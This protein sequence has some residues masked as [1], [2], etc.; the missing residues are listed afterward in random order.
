MDNRK[1]LADAKM[2]SQHFVTEAEKISMDQ[3]LD[4]MRKRLIESIGERTEAKEEP[5]EY[6]RE[7]QMH[8]LLQSVQCKA[9]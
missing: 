7:E 6:P 1:T 2:H 8:A 4:A 3:K 5:E 9:G